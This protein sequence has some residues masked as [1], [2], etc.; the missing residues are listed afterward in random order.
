M[1]PKITT[2]KTGQMSVGACSVNIF[3]ALMLW[4]RWADIDETWHICSMGLGTQ[5][6]GSGILNFGPCTTCGHPELSPPS[7]SSKLIYKQAMNVYKDKR[8]C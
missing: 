8:N 1:S 5:R 6:P 3:K 4:D 2:S 7:H